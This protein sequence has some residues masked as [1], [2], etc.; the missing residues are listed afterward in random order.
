MLERILPLLSVFA[1]IGSEHETFCGTGGYI[2]PKII[3]ANKRAKALHETFAPNLP[4]TYTS[5]VNI[6]AAVQGAS[7]HRLMQNEPKRRPT[8]AECLKDPWIIIIDIRN[9][10]LAQKRS[11]S[12]APS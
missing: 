3:Q 8:T 7:L 12:P 11:S 4:P 5:S 1:G 9:S 2:A 6:W 10:R